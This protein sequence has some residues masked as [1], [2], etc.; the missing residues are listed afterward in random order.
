MQ[1]LH[2]HVQGGHETFSDWECLHNNQLKQLKHYTHIHTHI[3]GNPAYMLSLSVAHKLFVC[4]SPQ[5]ASAKTT[6][7]PVFMT[8]LKKE[9]KS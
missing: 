6:A 5:L 4:L 1:H 8:T 7:A 3:L 9:K 2:T